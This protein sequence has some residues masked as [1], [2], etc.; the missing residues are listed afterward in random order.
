VAVVADSGAIYALYDAG[1]AHHAGVRSVIA[2]ERGPIIV[3]MAI[4]AEVDYLLREFLGVDAELDFLDG[5]AR[6]F[7][8]LVPL[9]QA[10]LARCQELIAQYRDI[11]P[12][13]ADVAVM[14]TAERMSIQ[15]ILTVDE[16]DFRAM[17]PKKGMTFVL[18]PSDAEP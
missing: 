3:P 9:T 17:R 12:G 8:T 15:R 18:L 13:L 7:Y 16:R 4:L 1:D 11:D 2:G 5:V 14:A 10:D 6:G